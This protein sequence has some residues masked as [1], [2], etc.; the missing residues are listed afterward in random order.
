MLLER[1]C[2]GILVTLCQQIHLILTLIG[3]LCCEKIIPADLSKIRKE[4]V[5]NTN[6]INK[7]L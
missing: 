3:F 7:C 2:S 4:D 1:L 6:K 5:D